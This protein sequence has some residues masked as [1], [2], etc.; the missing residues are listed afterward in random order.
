MP[1]PS[2]QLRQ[3]STVFANKSEKLVCLVL[4]SGSKYTLLQI[5]IDSA[6]NFS[7]DGGSG[8][9]TGIVAMQVGVT[10]AD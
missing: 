2:R 9:R 7:D 6:N 3:F 4:S 1:R 8:A 5:L 10:E